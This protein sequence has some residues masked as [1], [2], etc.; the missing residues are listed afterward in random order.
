VVERSSGGVP[1]VDEAERRSS[2]ADSSVQCL[3]SRTGRCCCGCFREQKLSYA[4]VHHGLPYWLLRVPSAWQKVALTCHC[5]LSWAATAYFFYWFGVSV[6]GSHFPTYFSFFTN[7]C[8]F[9]FCVWILTTALA[10]TTLLRVASAGTGLRGADHF[11]TAIR[12][13]LAGAAEVPLGSWP[14]A[15]DASLLLLSQVVILSE[16]IVVTVYWLTLC[17]TVEC[18]STRNLVS[19][20]QHGINLGW[21][22]FH[23]LSASRVVFSWGDAR[24]GLVVAV[25]YCLQSL[26]WQARWGKAVYPILDWFEGS[27]PSAL[28]VVPVLFVGYGLMH[29]AAVLMTRF[30]VRP[31]RARLDGT[32]YHER[33]SSST[34]ATELTASRTRLRNT[35]SDLS[36]G[37]SLVMQH[38]QRRAAADRHRASPAD[39]RRHGSTAA[40]SAGG[41]R[42]R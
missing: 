33:D 30:V 37:D 38:R 32:D 11:G 10:A 3:E 2:C 1:E 14:A 16:T 19:F 17:T 6:A 23:I 21:V 15:R 27:P 13:R 36:A 35:T 42:K 24:F 5:L 12:G 8:Y 39:R 9:L 22:V 25:A 26:I 34:A 29:V 28:I 40:S 18:R 4:W 20:H 7:W 41:G 31:L